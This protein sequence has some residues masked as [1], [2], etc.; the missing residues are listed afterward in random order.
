MRIGVI[1]AGA[2]G[3]TVAALLDRAGHE[4]EVTARGATLAAIRERGLRLDGKWG[5]HTAR[6]TANEAFTS[7]PEIAFVTTKA[8]DAASALAANATQLAGVPIVVVQNGLEGLETVRSV[9]PDAEAYGALALYAA[10]NVE[11]GRVTITAPADTVVDRSRA[12]ADLLGGVMPTKVTDN[13]R[14]AQWTK[15]VI[16]M[17]NGTPAA[18]GLSV[19]QT[20]AD[21]VLRPIVTA[22][23]REAARTGLAHGV[24]FDPLQG[25]THAAVRFVAAAPL[26][27]GQLVPLRMARHLGTVPNLGSTL[28]SI[29]RGQPTEIDYLNGAVVA[30]AVAV[31]RRAPVN[32]VIVTA[33]H[34]VE[35]SGVFLTPAELAA[36]TRR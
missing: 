12:A 4:V 28:Q 22:L 36:R 19:Q 11:P 30:Q 14:G 17:I 8:Q 26:W 16:N 23:L 32:E 35:R 15:L 33:V 3:G 20:I 2:I 31:G 25:L 13:F 27:A 29:K 18:T 24:R 1:G 21:P 10:Q 9:L 7:T 6:V 34:E 5:E